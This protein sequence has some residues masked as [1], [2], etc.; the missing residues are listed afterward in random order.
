METLSAVLAAELHPGSW[1]RRWSYRWTSI[2]VSGYQ[3]FRDGYYGNK[4]WDT[5]YRDQRACFS[6]PCVQYYVQTQNFFGRNDTL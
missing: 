2:C 5:T 3:L 6:L 1:S 4:W